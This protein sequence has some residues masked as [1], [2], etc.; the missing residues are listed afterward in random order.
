MQQTDTLSREDIISLLKHAHISP[1]EPRI[2]VYTFL[3]DHRIHPTVDTIFSSLSDMYPTLSRTTVY[4]TLKLLVDKQLIQQLNIENGE[5]RYD[6]NA[7]FH[8]HFKC[9][10]CGCVS[11]LF[12]VP[13]PQ[14]PAPSHHLLVESAQIN[15]Y[16]ICPVCMNG[17]DTQTNACQ[18]Q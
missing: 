11:D 13:S 9:R 10:V 14:L 18:S 12:D 4:S 17:N 15:Y 6:A 1:S 2:A 3:F 7:H 8:A 16:G 5:L